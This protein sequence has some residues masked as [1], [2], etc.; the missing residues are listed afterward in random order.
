MKKGKIVK[1]EEAGI[2]VQIEQQRGWM[3]HCEVLPVSATKG[4]ELEA[5]AGEV[6]TLESY[7]YQGSTLWRQAV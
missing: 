3:E 5:L 7:D 2:R 4:A 6:V 1:L